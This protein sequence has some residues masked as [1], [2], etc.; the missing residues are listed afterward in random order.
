VLIGTKNYGAKVHHIISEQKSG[1]DAIGTSLMQ[2]QIP[3]C[4]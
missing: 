1:Q 3:T 2:T 4:T